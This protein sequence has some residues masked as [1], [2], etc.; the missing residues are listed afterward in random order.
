ML[1]T[2]RKAGRHEHVYGWHNSTL[3]IPLANAMP[4][5]DLGRAIIKIVPLH[6]GR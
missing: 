1:L 5:D 6:R 2:I 4:I 3:T